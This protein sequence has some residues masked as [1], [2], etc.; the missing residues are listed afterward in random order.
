MN[1]LSKLANTVFVFIPKTGTTTIISQ[2]E[3]IDPVN[4][5]FHDPHRTAIQF[6]AIDPNFDSKFTF[7]MVRNPFQRLV[8]VWQHDIRAVLG[9]KNMQY[10]KFVDFNTWV[11]DRAVHVEWERYWMSLP[12]WSWVSDGSNIMVSKIYK[13]EQY[14]ESLIDLSNIL[15]INLD[16]NL[17][18]NKS[19]KQYHYNDIASPETKKIMLELCKLDCDK[20]NYE[21]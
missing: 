6:K 8:S 5:K 2:L 4:F 11:S 21:W 17:V 15:G 1:D 10:A 20:F 13:H 14:K 12:Q 18:E 9:T 16:Y 19:M 7:S 3:K